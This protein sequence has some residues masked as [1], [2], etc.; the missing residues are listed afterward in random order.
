LKNRRFLLGE[1]TLKTT[2]DYK[3]SMRP[4]QLLPAVPS[5][6]TQKKKKEDDEM[7]KKIPTKQSAA[8]ERAIAL[9]VESMTKDDQ[10]F[11]FVKLKKYCELTGDTPMAVHHR[12]RRR[13][14]ID[15]VHCKVLSRRRLWINPTEVNLWFLQTQK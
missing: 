7:K 8:A 1:K 14:W 9:S 12:R 15:G 5:L 6:L 4:A 3:N 11:T 13:Q 10:P 2:F